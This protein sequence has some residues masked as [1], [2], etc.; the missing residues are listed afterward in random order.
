MIV[1][2]RVWLEYRYKRTVAERREAFNGVLLY[3]MESCEDMTF[4]P[5]SLSFNLWPYRTPEEAAVSN[6]LAGLFQK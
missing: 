4:V 2:D 3:K 1:P 5:S 6:K